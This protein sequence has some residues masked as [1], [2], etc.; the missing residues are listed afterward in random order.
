MTKNPFD[1]FAKQFFEALLSPYGEVRLNYEVPGEP[2]FIDVLFAPSNQS[3]IPDSLGLL[4]R[5]GSN[6][7]LIEPFRKQ[8]T[9]D[10]IRSCLYKLFHVQFNFQRIARSDEERLSED[11]L[12]QLWIIAPSIS[13]NLI[14]YS[15]A[16]LSEDWISG[17]YFLSGILKTAIIAVNELP[18]TPETTF[19][20]LFGKG[21]IQ[22]QAVEEIR[23]LPKEDNRRAL[24]LQML[25]TWKVSIELIQP[26][27][28][29][30]EDEDLV[31]ILSEAY[32]EWE[33]R[34]ERQGMHLMVENLLKARFGEVDAELANTIPLLLAL[35]T[36][37]YTALLLQ[38]SAMSREEFI[39]RFQN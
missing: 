6:P 19:F 12:A 15:T 38:L 21:D 7:C 3:T 8:P 10:E 18:R 23:A 9:Y 30:I 27:D 11:E 14:K 13:E 20:R 24:V 32:Q 17:I 4:S 39:A 2:R 35:P 28:T 1:Q 31:M 33:Q 5:I 37:E 34:T 36:Q 22:K 26:E 16:T 25:S 29:D